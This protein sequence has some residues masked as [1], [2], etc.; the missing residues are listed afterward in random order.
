MRKLE[1][2]GTGN[3]IKPTDNVSEV[4]KLSLNTLRTPSR[5]KEYLYS[6]MRLVLTCCIAEYILLG[7][8]YYLASYILS[9]T[10]NIAGFIVFNKK[11]HYYI[12][13]LFKVL[14]ALLAVSSVI[15][16]CICVRKILQNKLIKT[17]VLK[18]NSALIILAV[19]GVLLFID[20]N[21]TLFLRMSIAGFSIK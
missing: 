14:S 1:V 13:S 6:M 8:S 18:L 19:I 15:C 5:E 20:V 9:T 17:S 2:K 7:C 21:S 4:D 3:S 10:V 11:I 12:F 16:E